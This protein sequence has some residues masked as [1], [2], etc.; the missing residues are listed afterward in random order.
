MEIGI[1]A[2]LL[3]GGKSGMATYIRNL[4]K[5]L[6]HEDMKNQYS[7]FMARNES[8]LIPVTNPRFSKHLYSSILNRPLFSMAWHN[9][10][11]PQKKHDLVHIPGSRRIP[12]LK[13]TKIVATVHDLA[14][15]SIDAKYDRARMYFN[16]R[17]VPSMIRRADHV[18]A[19]S[20]QTKN[21]LI[22]FVGYPE[23]KITVVYPGIDHTLFRPINPDMAR[24]QL[25]RL[26]GLTKPFF[27][28]VSR[29]EHPAKN[30]M[31]LIDSFERFK[32]EN[33]SEH[34]LVLAGAN[35]RGAD[36]IRARA[37]ESPVKDDIAFLG[38]V[39]TETLPFLYSACDLM[40]FPS[41][42]EGFGF[43]ILEAL[44]CGTPVA[45]SNTSAMREIAGNRI[46][47]FDP[48]SSEAIARNMAAAVARGRGTPESTD[49]I[50]YAQTFN[51][52]E[53]ARRVMDVYRLVAG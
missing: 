24:E 7:L 9:I 32:L 50:R 49:A 13:R 51:W 11:L 44:A 17:V 31:R 53:T 28:Y 12:L 42:Y 2:F 1:P 6:Q 4:L 48:A 37:Q 22:R 45:C 23:N 38:F 36:V 5:G 16:L 18:I 21:D 30:H 41:L 33:D 26:H 43:P 3:E 46:P 10:S 20:E 40:V 8:H 27:V 52:N 34:Q 47:T 29:L 39:P 15:F 25:A 19:V 14:P 35:W